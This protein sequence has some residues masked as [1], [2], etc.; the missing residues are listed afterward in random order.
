MFSPK[1]Q[2]IIQK[3]K[4]QLTQCYVTAT[5]VCPWSCAKIDNPSTWNQECRDWHLSPS[6]QLPCAQDWQ[7]FRF[8]TSSDFFRTSS[9][10]LRT[11]SVLLEPLPSFFKAKFLEVS[12]LQSLEPASSREF[13][14]VVSKD[15]FKTNL[16]LVLI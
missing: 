1:K 7:T 15:L 12:F 11:S 6:M 10:F 16:F 8:L 13:S 9:D 4:E 5:F 3:E 14:T 2:S